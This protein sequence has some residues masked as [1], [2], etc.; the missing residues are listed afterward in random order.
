MTDNTA[1]TGLLL[2]VKC[3][4]SFFNSMALSLHWFVK[5]NVKVNTDCIAPCRE[6]TCKVLRYGMRSQ[7]TS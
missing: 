6:H 7:G 1:T 3:S 5:V 2:A 4:Q